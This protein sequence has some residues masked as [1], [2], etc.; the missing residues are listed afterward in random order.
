MAS[1]TTES[2]TA[3]LASIVGPENVVEDLAERTFYSTDIAS[4]GATALAVVRPGSTDQL[5]QVLRLCAAE[6]LAVVP[7]GGGFSYTGGYTPTTPDTVVVDMRGFDE[8]VEINEEDMYVRVGA[9][10]TWQALYETLKAR[11]L[12]TP[13]F[14]PM[15]G[16]HATVGGALSQG[17]FFLGSTE[18]GTTAESVLSLEVVLADGQVIHTGSDAAKGRTPFYRFF[19]P[20]LTGLFL[21]DTGAMGFKTVATLKLIQAPASQAYGSFAFPDGQATIAALSDIARAG[22][23]GEAYAWDPHFVKVMSEATTGTRQD[24][25]FLWGVFRASAGL[26]DGLSA[27]LRIAV[28]GKKVFR[29]ATHIVQVMMDDLS[30][31]GA[32][33]RLK[34]VRAIAIRHGGEE[35]APSVP[36]ATRG[37][38]FT[39]F[40]VP[41]RRSTLRNLPVNSLYPHSRAQGALRA[42]RAVFE[43]EREA[44]ERHG[45]TSGTVFFAVGR[46]ALCI[47]PLLYWQDEEHYLHN[48]IEQRSDLEALA[49][50][51]ERPEATRYVMQLREK[52]KQVMKA[53]GAVHVQIGK[54]YQYLPELE[55]RVA[56]LVHA[57]KAAVDPQYRVNPGSLGLTRK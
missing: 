20:D 42:I 52:L 30:A 16:Y 13:Y 57:V 18:H 1:A 51:D 39:P 6:N 14:G 26:V 17:S 11:R 12:R 56:E 10:C 34:Q 49:D 41:E 36:R 24:L 31:A 44:M 50:Y 48:R 2:M 5:S 27:C 46:T 47:E 54:S 9:G 21:A 29:P 35:L 15:S 19:G 23:A 37:T 3:R 45:V 7:R 38:P 33:N 55:P 40:N 4:R 8:I 25:R 22:L 28:N 53:N 32:A 43:E